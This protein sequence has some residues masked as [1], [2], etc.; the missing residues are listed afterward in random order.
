MPRTDQSIQATK[1]DSKSDL[2]FVLGPHR[3]GTSATTRFVSLL[4]NVPIPGALLRPRNSDNETGFWEP[5][6]LV[7]LNRKLMSSVGLDWDSIAPCRTEHLPNSDRAAL[8]ERTKQYLTEITRS[9]NT[10]LLKD[11]RLCR[12]LPIWLE[13][14]AKLGKR[15]SAIHAVRSPLDAAASMHAR[16]D[17][18]LQVGV[19]IWIRHIVE[20]EAY[21][22][23]LP[24]VFINYETLI[25]NWQT[26]AAA[27]TPLCP[28]A[29]A[30]P[31][32]STQNAIER[33]LDP[34]L[35]HHRIQQWDETVTPQLSNLVEE[36]YACT[37]QLTDNPGSAIAMRRLDRVTEQINML[38][39][40]IGHT[41][42]A[43]STRM[44]K[45]KDTMKT[46]R[47]RV[48]MRNRTNRALRWEVGQLA[49]LNKVHESQAALS[50]APLEGSPI[51]RH[52]RSEFSGMRR[53][54]R[55][56]FATAE[57]NPRA[58]HILFVLHKPERAVD[59]QELRAIKRL[60]ELKKHRFYVHLLILHPL[61]QP[62]AALKPLLRHTHNAAHEI[63]VMQQ[64]ARAASKADAQLVDDLVCLIAQRQI[65]LLMLDCVCPI[66]PA[67]AAYRIG[68]P[69][70]LYLRGRNA[71]DGLTAAMLKA[72]EDAVTAA[73]SERVN[74]L[75]I[76]GV[77]NL[78]PN[79]AAS[80][81]SVSKLG[82]RL[83]IG[84]AIR[85]IRSHENAENWHAR[86][87]PHLLPAESGAK[88]AARLDLIIVSWNHLPELQEVVRRLL[89]LTE[90]PF[91]LTIC[92]NASRTPVREY[93][94]ALHQ[95]HA[96]ITVILSHDNVLVGPASNMA[97]DQGAADVVIYVCAK[98]GFALRSGW[99]SAFVDAMN[100]DSTIG[101]A[102][103][104]STPRN[105]PT[106]RR[107]HEG[108]PEFA[109]FRNRQWANQDPDASFQYV[110]GGLFALR[111]AMYDEIGGFSYRTPHLYTD[112]EYSY[113][114]QS[115]GWRIGSTPRAPSS[116]SRAGIGL[117]AR[118]N[119]S[120][121]AIHPGKLEDL[122][123]MDNLVHGRTAL[124]NLCG[125]TGEVFTQDGDLLTCVQCGSLPADRALMRFIAEQSFTPAQYRVVLTVDP[126]GCFGPMIDLF[127]PRVLDKW[128]SAAI[129]QELTDAKL[130]DLVVLTQ[131][132]AGSALTA[133]QIT[134]LALTLAPGGV[135]VAVVT[136]DVQT[137]LEDPLL[138]GSFTVEM[139][140]TY[141]S[142]ATGL[143]EVHVIKLVN[144]VRSK[145]AGQ[146]G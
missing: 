20:A 110:Q 87:R 31:G 113:Y 115:R 25:T 111:R 13:A 46:L 33:F 104:P 86:R 126:R 62:Q 22:R 64:Q 112:T 101:L 1:I 39:S 29:K 4:G 43:E 75:V 128:P 50:Q 11:P 5:R 130:Q 19:W 85:Q 133:G 100:A 138:S 15:V 58:G 70:C 71:S 93:L 109:E 55:T 69:A 59:E 116:S 23:A 36:I 117:T 102:G 3:C 136:A 105:F 139:G 73:I 76:D 141:S 41:L 91:H 145:P 17:L 27:V 114:A 98:E 95:A 121:V 135:L 45:A 103:T 65:S 81:K 142:S 72:D 28:G 12:L 120:A 82:G 48:A 68:V 140:T 7:R 63:T 143:D 144:Q 92:D 78:D 96:N 56:V 80:M 30:T 146:H 90:T 122:R 67:V 47:Q 134:E 124:C 131:P 10:V 137:Q 44:D 99:E 2:I 132:E 53:R 84:E 61:S 108:L 77:D 66:E 21:T 38:D 37:Q 40:L 79:V 94:K 24:R 8:V 89:E 88:Q 129:A 125:K 32:I 52:I 18:A 57:P 14:A 35:R 26:V 51:P 106:M 107:L 16:N 54:W 119:E 6:D 60:R 9:H 97:I 83:P 34:A 127:Q 49:A 42:V 118:L 74:H 123:W